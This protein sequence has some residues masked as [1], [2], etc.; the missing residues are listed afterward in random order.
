MTRAMAALSPSS[1]LSRLAL[2]GRDHRLMNAVFGSQFRQGLIPLDRHQ[3]D[4]RLEINPVTLTR[5]LSHET[6]S[7]SSTGIA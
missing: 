2:P 6:P 5:N 7:F 3:S 4:L 1:T